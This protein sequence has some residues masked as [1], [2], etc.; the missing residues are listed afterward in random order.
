M[1][2]RFGVE[3]SIIAYGTGDGSV[4]VH[5]ILKSAKIC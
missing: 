5:N 2:V 3:D 4:K 1:V